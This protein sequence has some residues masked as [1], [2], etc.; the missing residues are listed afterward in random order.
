M[1]KTPAVHMKDGDSPSL[2][3]KHETSHSTE[4]AATVREE[5]LMTR[6]GLNL[7][8]F[9]KRNYGA[10]I[11]ELD[12]PMRT[13]H[14]HMIAIGGSIGAGFFVGSGGALFKG[15]S[16]SLSLEHG[17]TNICGTILICIRARHPFF[18]ISPSSA[19]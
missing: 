12:R 5:S 19:L 9:R 14:L 16:D 3:P 8:S 1:A 7:T 10:E 11:V 18:W 15:V 17:R 6:M 2:Q 4:A 13:R